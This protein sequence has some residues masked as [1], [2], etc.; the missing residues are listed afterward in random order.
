VSRSGYSDDCDNWSLIRWRGAVNAAIRGKRGQSLLRELAAAMDAMPLKELVADEFQAEGTFCAL[1]TV[2]AMR[3]MDLS[4]LDPEDRDGVAK[5]FG[6]AEALAAEIM[7]LN[8]QYDYGEYG[9]RPQ[10]MEELQAQRR[11]E[12]ERRWTRVRQWVAQHL[13]KVP[14]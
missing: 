14:A 6:L 4:K 2:G 13:E 5:A 8:D 10:T 11:R 1:G 3:G 7:D 12:R 9:V